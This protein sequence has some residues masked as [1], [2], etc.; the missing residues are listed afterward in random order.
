MMYVPIICY[1]QQEL[2][3]D[4]I[5]Y[6]TMKHCNDRVEI[7]VLWILQKE[8]YI[9]VLQLHGHLFFKNGS[10]HALTNVPSRLLQLCAASMNSCASSIK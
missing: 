2:L 10:H 3:A 1:I 5:L 4:L 9:Y 8:F 6:P 7:Q